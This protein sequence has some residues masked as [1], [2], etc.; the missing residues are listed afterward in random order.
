[1]NDI[2]KMQELWQEMSSWMTTYMKSFYSPEAAKTA[3]SHLEIKSAAT[4]FFDDA[5]IVDG[6][7]L[8]EKH[9]WMVVK[10]CERLANHLN[11]NE[12]DKI[13]AQMIGLFHDVGRFYQ[14]TVYRT[15]NDALSE[16]HAKLGLKVIKDLPFMEKLSPDDF[17][18][19]KFAIAN[20]NAREIATTDNK[21]FLLFAKLIRDADKIDIYRV[22]KPF[23][24]PTDGTGCSEDFI[25]LFVAGKQCDYTKMRTQDDRK[26]VRLMWVY[27]IY[28]SWSLQ[29][30]VKQNYIEDIIKNLVHDEKMLQGIER[31][32]NYMQKKLQTKDIWQD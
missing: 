2:V 17:A 18:T 30:I 9:T 3:K 8:K 31:L 26:L 13:L 14:F 27:D 25:D 5:Q 29:Q 24:G 22:L 21:R 28:F 4:I 12:H 20:H 7:I 6:I 15:F 11:L 32:R 10:N 19:L 16:N 1:M 23:L